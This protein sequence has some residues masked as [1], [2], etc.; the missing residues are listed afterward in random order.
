M[1]L[2]RRVWLARWRR[3]ATCLTT[4]HG[5]CH[6]IRELSWY[7]AADAATFYPR[8]A[9]R[10]RPPA[11]PPQQPVGRPVRSCGRLASREVALGLRLRWPS[12][13]TPELH[14]WHFPAQPMS[15]MEFSCP[16]CS[17]QCTSSDAEPDC[18]SE[19]CRE[20]TKGLGGP[21]Q[22]PVLV[23]AAQPDQVAEFAAAAGASAG[24]VLVRR[25]RAYD[26][27]DEHGAKDF[28]QVAPTCHT[29]SHT[30]A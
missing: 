14:S 4:K 19:S 3:N 20:A 1:P 21:R 17:L 25:H 9:A 26:I 15:A 2:P 23:E 27:S 28:T 8:C 30:Y 12:A 16:H 6:T 11:R 7:E 29:R 24:R 18:P 22:P 5:L 10:A 13:H